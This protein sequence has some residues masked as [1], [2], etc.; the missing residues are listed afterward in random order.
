MNRWTMTM[1]M[2]LGATSLGVAGCTADAADELASD[3]LASG[4]RVDEAEEALITPIQT[5]PTF[6]PPAFPSWSSPAG[7]TSDVLIIHKVQNTATKWATFYAFADFSQFE[8]PYNA[9][10][11]TDCLNSYITVS[12][13]TGTSSSGT[14]SAADTT[15]DNSEEAGSYGK[16]F[17]ATPSVGFNAANQ[18][19]ILGCGVTFAV[20][21]CDR[22]N[23][24]SNENYVQFEVYGIGGD[25]T[26]GQLYT[27]IDYKTPNLANCL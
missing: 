18:L 1:M 19:V 14:L 7:W 24:A 4:E 12:V 11:I 5:M 9:D 25:G 22:Y 23:F 6:S 13:R 27:Q 21:D 16:K 10:N 3:E 17:F 20:G 15:P 2:I 8:G 26:A